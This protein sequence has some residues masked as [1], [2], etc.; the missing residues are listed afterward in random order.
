MLNK[1]ETLAKFSCCKCKKKSQC[2]IYTVIFC[3]CFW[4]GGVR[5]SSIKI[6]S[7]LYTSASYSQII[8]VS[9]KTKTQMTIHSDFQEKIF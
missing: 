3:C 1:C 7:V 4:L 2:I 8:M 5:L 9:H 6:R